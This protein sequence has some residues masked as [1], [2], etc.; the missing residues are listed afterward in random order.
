MN[1]IAR[2]LLLFVFNI[3]LPTNVRA[4]LVDEISNIED[5]LSVGASESLQVN[6][7]RWFMNEIHACL[8]LSDHY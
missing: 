7:K 3:D 2:E 6:S 1:D 8:W 4:T 5:R